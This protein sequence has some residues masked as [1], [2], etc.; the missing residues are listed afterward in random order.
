M[1]GKIILIL[2]KSGFSTLAFNPNKILLTIKFFFNFS[3][4]NSIGLD[5]VNP[6][7]LKLLSFGLK[8]QKK[9]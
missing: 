3:L 2:A 9:I 5:W 6:F 7:S 1:S 8:F 4:T